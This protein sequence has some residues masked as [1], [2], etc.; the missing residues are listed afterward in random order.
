MTEKDIIKKVVNDTGV[1]KEIVE[2]VFNDIFKVIGDS[3]MKEKNVQIKNFGSFH[4][5]HLGRRVVG[6]HYMTGEEATSPEHFKVTFLAYSDLKR[7]AERKLIRQQ[8]K[9]AEK[10]KQEINEE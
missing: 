7:R 6:V 2:P 8:K 9:Q 10:E 1:E 4:L 3:V 5:K